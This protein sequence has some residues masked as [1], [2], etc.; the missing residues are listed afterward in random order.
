[1]KNKIILS[2]VI[3]TFGVCW[4]T[5]QDANQKAAIA[6]AKSID[7]D[8]DTVLLNPIEKPVF[9]W[10]DGV[11]VTSKSWDIQYVNVSKGLNASRWAIVSA[12]MIAFDVR[13]TTENNDTSNIVAPTPVQSTLEEGKY[14]RLY[15]KMTSLLKGSYL[16]MFEEIEDEGKLE[17]AKKMMEDGLVEY[18]KARNER[19]KTIAEQIQKQKEYLA[20]SAANPEY[21]DGVWKGTF[22]PKKPV[23]LTFSGN[24]L[25]LHRSFA[26]GKPFHKE[27]TFLFDKETIIIFFE[28][29]VIT[30]KQVW[31]YEIKDGVLNIA[32]APLDLSVGS[33]NGKY[34]KGN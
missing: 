15:S 10:L 12:D 27:G 31:Y 29:Y 8:F 7:F 20:F 24:K 21:L 23:T 6:Y 5:A 34:K 14:Y 4:A 3:F 26:M 22:T 17:Q 11:T 25:I 30:K 32:N 19:I 13:Q 28:N 33:I 2:I 16:F 1:M 18:E 9:I